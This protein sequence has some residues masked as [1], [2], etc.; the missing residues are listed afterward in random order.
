MTFA[1][2]WVPAPESES[3]PTYQSVLALLPASE[4]TWTAAAAEDTCEALCSQNAPE[5]VDTVRWAGHSAALSVYA[6]WAVTELSAR[7]MIAPE[8]CRGRLHELASRQRTIPGRPA[9]W[10]KP[11]WWGSY[12]HADHWAELTERHPGAVELGSGVHH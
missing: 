8:E 3:A 9:G 4:L 2:I 12:L 1:E 7:G 10:A 6:M 5:T 11:R